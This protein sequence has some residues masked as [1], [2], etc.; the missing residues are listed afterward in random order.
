MTVFHAGTRREG[1]ALLT[2]G[3]RVLNVT[4]LAPDR[5]EARRRA[6][7]AVGKIRFE[8]MHC[9]GDIAGGA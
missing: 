8:D 1:D 7:A 5:E 3:G 2:A 4:A 6:Y 9:R